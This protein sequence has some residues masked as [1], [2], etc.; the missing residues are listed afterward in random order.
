MRKTLALTWFVLLVSTTVTGL[1]AAQAGPAA[2]CTAREILA[3][4]EGKGVDPKLG[5]LSQQ[6]KRPPFSAWNTFQLLAT[7]KITTEKSAAA[8][9]TLLPPGKLTLTLQDKVTTKGK[10]RIRIDVKID[11]KKRKNLVSTVLA[12]DGGKT[13]FPVAGMP[14]KDGTYVLALACN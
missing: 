2:N 1:P 12:F 7:H 10:A 11:Y 3:S 4:N 14:Y 6:L 8:S 5:D 13:L 9:A